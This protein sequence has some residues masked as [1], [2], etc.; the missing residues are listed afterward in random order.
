MCT[1]TQPPFVFFPQG[2]A[3]IFFLHVPIFVS[4]FR[5][6]ATGD[7]YQHGWLMCSIDV[8]E[9]KVKGKGNEMGYKVFY[10]VNRIGSSKVVISIHI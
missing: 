5:A 4:V 2:G 9:E 3:N 7:R 6:L 10:D 8:I 1:P